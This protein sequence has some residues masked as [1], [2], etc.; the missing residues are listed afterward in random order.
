MYRITPNTSTIRNL[1]TL[2]LLVMFISSNVSAREQ[3]LA[4]LKA[5][6][7]YNIAKFT[8]WP[9]S[10]LSTEESEFKLCLYG[11]DDTI[12]Q[13]KLLSNR[14][15]QSYPILVKEVTTELAIND[16][17]LLYI[18]A[19]ENRRYGYVLSLIKQK[20]ILTIGNDSLFL[21]HGGLINL[22]ELEQRLQFE[23]NMEQLVHSK[24][25]LSSKLL[26]LGKL[27]EKPR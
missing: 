10:V 2:V 12:S 14:S 1:L 21:R 27:I 16:C 23:V 13:L 5:A 17:H 4:S 9:E 19:K 24:L 3:T 20:T 15:M 22:T 26:S 25:T 7:V 8:R 18:S 11:N 6:Y